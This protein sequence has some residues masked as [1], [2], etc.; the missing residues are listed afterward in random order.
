[1][2]SSAL[3]K[4]SIHFPPGAQEVPNGATARKQDRDL[5]ARIVAG[6]EDAVRDLYDLFGQRMYTYALRLCDDHATAEDI[7]QETLV[8]AWRTASQFRGDGCLL[9]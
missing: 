7:T 6:D 5:L 3:V 9:A 2:Y 8:I 1:M 4:Q